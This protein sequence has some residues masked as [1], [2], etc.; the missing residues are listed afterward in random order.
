MT[1]S[2]ACIFCQIIRGAVPAF[3]LLETEKVLAFLSI[4]PLARGHALVVPKF[5]GERLDR[6]PDGYLAELLPVAK[7]IA[8]RAFAI[9]GIDYNLLQN[10]GR[11]AH[12]EIDHVHLHIIP[13]PSANEGL[14]ITETP[15]A[16]SSDELGRICE[17]MVQS[18][19]E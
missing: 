7:R 10:N 11:L 6:V 5:H 4:H 1:L 17:E 16:M 14:S 2:E 19:K 9:R 3:K 12:Q 13:K 15:M 8:E 18:L